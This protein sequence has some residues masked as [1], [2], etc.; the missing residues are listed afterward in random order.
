MAAHES[1]YNN[2]FLTN[3]LRGTQQNCRK[4]DPVT[5]SKIFLLIILILAVKY[6]GK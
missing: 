4:F 3:P 1:L 2:W 5:K 6:G